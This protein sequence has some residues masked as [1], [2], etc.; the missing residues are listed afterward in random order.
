MGDNKAMGE[1]ATAVE[2][3]AAPA[4]AESPVA[5]SRGVGA[6]AAGGE[7]TLSD[8]APEAPAELEQQKRKN[9]DRVAQAFDDARKFRKAA[10]AEAAEKRRYA[11]ELEQAKAELA[12]E[13][14]DREAFKAQLRKDYPTVLTRDLG[15]P[16]EEIAARLA[17]DSEISPRLQAEL[18]ELRRAFSE[19]EQKR[20]GFEQELR[21]RE[22]AADYD[23]RVSYDVERIDKL[24]TVESAEYV[25]ALSPRERHRRIRA[26][27]ENAVQSGVPMTHEQLLAE[28]NEDPE[29]QELVTHVRGTTPQRART[30]E[31]PRGVLEAPK[32]PARAPTAREK[33][34]PA[35]T[36]PRTVEERRAAAVAKLRDKKRRAAQAKA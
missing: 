1:P 33:A 23:R 29:I 9:R 35:N 31:E 4:G 34:A 13:R 28:L 21:R 24:A 26:A 27:I 18:E 12:K 8:V 16:R 14:A 7:E 15:M 11:N 32:V 22:E 19:S 30:V 17:D 5:E 10:A 20:A 25:A 2:T 6:A 3:T 36:R